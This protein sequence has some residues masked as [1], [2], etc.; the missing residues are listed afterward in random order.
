MRLH[1]FTL[2]SNDLKLY[3][4]NLMHD[5]TLNQFVAEKDNIYI[6]VL[7]SSFSKHLKK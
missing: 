1:F 6:I 5:V 2:N 4:A 7:Q 3:F